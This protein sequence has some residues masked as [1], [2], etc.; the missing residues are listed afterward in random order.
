MVSV[1]TGLLGEEGRVK[2][3]GGYMTI[4]RIPFTFNLGETLISQLSM[5]EETAVTRESQ[6]TGSFLTCLVPDS[7]PGRLGASEQSVA[8]PI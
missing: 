6:V 2:P 8:M 7:N 4:K 3:F 5:V 1:C